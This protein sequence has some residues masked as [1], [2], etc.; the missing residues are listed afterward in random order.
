MPKNFL[1]GCG[2]FV[3][4]LFVYGCSSSKVH[5]HSYIATKKR[6][7]QEMTGN[8]GYLKGQP[9][10]EE[11]NQQRKDTRQVFVVEVERENKEEET[12]EETAAPLSA[13]ESTLTE[14]TK[15]EV[16]QPSSYQPRVKI[17]TNESSAIETPQGSKP[18]TSAASFIEYTV[19]KDDTLQKI[20]KKFYNSYSKWPRIYDANRDVIK[21]PDRL[22]TGM[23]IKIPQP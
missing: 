10:P 3:L 9:Q 11:I 17:P 6:V 12:S 7:D 20:S 16:R 1:K 5:V 2:I 23:I 8:F 22:K 18:L 15:R 4:F 19:E 14:E 21:T 13:R